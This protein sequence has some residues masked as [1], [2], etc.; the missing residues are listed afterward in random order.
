M[1]SRGG[2]AKMPFD[3]PILPFAQDGLDLCTEAKHFYGVGLAHRALG[4]IAMAQAALTSAVKHFQ[5]ARQTFTAID[6]QSEVARTHLA[7]AALAQ[8]QGHHHEV[9][10]H[11]RTAHDLFTSLQIPQYVERTEHLARTYQITLVPR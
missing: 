4:R 7:W 6:V 9:V 5:N 3:F 2:T 10:A 11:L 8:T 1:W